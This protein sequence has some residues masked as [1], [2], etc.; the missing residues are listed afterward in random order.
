[1]NFLNPWVLFLLYGA[2]L[3]LLVLGGRWV[4]SYRLR[5]GLVQ[6]SGVLALLG[7]L[8]LVELFSFSRFHKRWDLTGNRRHSFAG[9]T[10]NLLESLESPLEATVFVEE[11]VS[12]RAYEQLLSTSHSIGVSGFDLSILNGAKFL[13]CSS[14]SSRK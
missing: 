6:W 1:M 9:L 7:I 13:F 2:L 12:R 14:S 4:K 5:Q 10:V 11:E 3:T 8:L